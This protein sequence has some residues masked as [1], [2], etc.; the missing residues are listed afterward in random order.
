MDQQKGI[1]VY[2]YNQKEAYFLQK[3]FS[4][5]LDSPVLL[6]SGTDLLNE[7]VHSILHKNTG[8]H[9]VD[10]S[11]KIILFFSM[12]DSE[13]RTILSH[14][15]EQV[16]RPIFCGLTPHNM[17]WEFQDLIEHLLAEKEMMKKQSMQDQQ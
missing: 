8:F 1:L 6:K 10:A 2:G 5:L 16:T 15:P 12:T 14:F 11:P 13:I 3:T 7:K 9:Y 17:Q 4:Q